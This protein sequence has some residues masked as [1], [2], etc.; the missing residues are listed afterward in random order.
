MLAGC[1]G[2]LNELHLWHCWSISGQNETHLNVIWR[3]LSKPLGVICTTAV[4]DCCFISYSCRGLS[5]KWYVLRSRPPTAGE[6]RRTTILSAEAAGRQE[7]IV[8]PQSE[9][10]MRRISFLYLPVV[11][12]WVCDLQCFVSTSVLLFILLL[13][14]WCFTA[15]SPALEAIKHHLLWSTNELAAHLCTFTASDWTPKLWWASFVNRK[16]VWEREKTALRSTR[17]MKCCSR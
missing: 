6:M 16:T 9:E 3:L 12:S 14:S 5:N 2:K 1:W 11:P 4:S 7:F 10:F 8:L 17:R 15:S 13:L